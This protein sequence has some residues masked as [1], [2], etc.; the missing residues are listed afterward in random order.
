VD[1][2]HAF[3]RRTGEFRGEHGGTMEGVRRQETEVGGQ[4]S[5]VGIKTVATED[6]EPF[7]RLRP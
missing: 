7:D 2:K 3:E 6:T 1:A 4:R 5:G